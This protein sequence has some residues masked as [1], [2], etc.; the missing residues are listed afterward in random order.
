MSSFTETK[1]ITEEILVAASFD[2]VKLKEQGFSAKEL[3]VVGFDAFELK[4]VGFTPIE[5]RVAGF[6]P[7]EL[8]EAGFNVIQVHEAGFSHRRLMQ[9]GFGAF[10]M[11]ENLKLTLPQL[12]AAG[13]S[14]PH[15]KSLGFTAAELRG[16]GLK[17]VEVTEY[18]SPGGKALFKRLHQGFNNP[19]LCFFIFI[20][21]LYRI[22]TCWLYQGR[23]EAFG[24][25]AS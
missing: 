17:A 13:F 6:T 16:I 10:V 20:C 4:T 22:I 2:G 12:K 5:L 11:Q 18:Y 24:S 23:N 21:F 1:V 25:L 15:F 8:R 19:V 3:K 14:V 7:E 9:A